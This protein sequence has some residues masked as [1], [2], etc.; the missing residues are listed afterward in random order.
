LSV[1]WIVCERGEVG[2]GVLAIGDVSGGGV[3]GRETRGAR[4]RFWVAS[5]GCGVLASALWGM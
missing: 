4:L 5:V 1:L 2:L 3:Y